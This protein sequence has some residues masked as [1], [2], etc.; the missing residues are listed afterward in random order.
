ML[1][2]HAHVTEDAVDYTTTICAFTRD[3]VGLVLPGK[4]RYHLRPAG[5]MFMMTY[6]MSMI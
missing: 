3:A 2:P 1:A 4:P 6:R 5:L